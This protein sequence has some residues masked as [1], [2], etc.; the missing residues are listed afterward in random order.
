MT[1][2]ALLEELKG[3]DADTWNYLVKWNVNMALPETSPL[4]MY[5]IQGCIQRACE[6]RGWATTLE[7]VSWYAP[8][9]RWHAYISTGPRGCDTKD[10]AADS[11]VEALL[12]AYIAAVREEAK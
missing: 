5:I 7:Y 12:M 8:A 10:T 9:R 11:P 4:S 6:K 1:L 2:A 3:V